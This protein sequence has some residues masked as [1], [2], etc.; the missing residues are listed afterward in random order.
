M[1][2]HVTDIEISKPPSN[3]MTEPSP[4][5]ANDATRQLRNE[6]TARSGSRVVFYLIAVLLTATALAK[7]WML[8]TDSF[9]D[10]RVG[11]PREILWLSVGFEL[12]LAFENF[13]VRDHRVLALINTVV[14]S[15]F[16]IFASIRW[17]LGY[18]S[19]GCS[20]SLELPVWIF[21][22]IDLVIVSWFT[23]SRRSR[24]HLVA[25]GHQL[26]SDWTG[27]SS[28]TRGWLAGMG[29]FASLIIGMQSP[30]AAPLRA[31]VLSEPAIKATVQHDDGL[32]LNQQ[33]P[34]TVEIEN[35]SSRPAKNIGIS[36]SC[37]CFDLIESPVS[38]SIPANGRIALPLAIKPIK[39][40]PLHQRVELYLDHPDQFRVSVDVFGFVKGVK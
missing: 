23:A 40:G 12:W 3:S 18:A 20:G 37:R 15:A 10:V 33:S 35:R 13:R 6:Q 19:C 9:A 34:G 31:M 14:F 11:I 29:L 32:S 39:S 5:F 22:L 2:I 8:V 27:W 21:I 24:S 16:A 38:K 1:N 17:L 7:L 26:V 28:E 4:A 30:L 25:G 36:R